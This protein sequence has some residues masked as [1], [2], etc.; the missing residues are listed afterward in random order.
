MD[1]AEGRPR[2]ATRPGRRALI[3]GGLAAS[4]T[5]PFRPARARA[6]ISGVPA[7]GHLAF[8]VWRKGSHIGEH[9]LMFQQEGDDLIV[10]ID[11]HILVKIGPVPVASYGHSCKERWSGTQFQGLEAISHS[12]PG[13]QQ[14][15]IARRTSDGIYVE[16]AAGA[17]Y[18]IA[19]DTLPMSHWNRQ[20]MKAPLFNPQDGK[21]LKETSRTMKGEEMVKLADGASVKATR[22][23]VTG[24]ASV[25]DWYDTANVWTALHGR[26]VDGSYIDYRRL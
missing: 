9:A 5:L 11:V 3:L 16:P 2:I 21:L 7:G 18:T 14:H 19:G 25:D 6:V 1:D 17:P 22:Y 8:Q 15:V 20:V 4:A 13:A 26:V 12:S 24:D 10:Q 23:A